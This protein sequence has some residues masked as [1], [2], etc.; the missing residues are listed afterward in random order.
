MND[1]YMTES[2]KKRK[3]GLEKRKIESAQNE[4]KS[5]REAWTDPPTRF[6]DIPTHNYYTKMLGFYVKTATMEMGQKRLAIV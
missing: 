6:L 5:D 3:A 2:K 1:D 4:L